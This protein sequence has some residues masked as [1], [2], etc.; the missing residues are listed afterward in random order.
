MPALRPRRLTCGGSREN[1][2]AMR[3]VAL[4]F[5][6]LW[7]GASLAAQTPVVSAN[8]D[9]MRIRSAT[10]TAAAGGAFNVGVVVEN[11]NANA[12]LPTTW[13]RWW[14]F[15]VRNLNAAG[16]TMTFT[17]DSAS[18]YT[19]VILPVWSLST[20]GV[21]FSAYERCPTS[22]TPTVLSAGRHRFTLTTPPGTVAI[23]VAKYFPYTVARKNAWVASLQGRPQLRSTTVI[24]SSVQGRPI[25]MLELTDASVPDA[26]K[27]RVWIHSGIHPSESTSYLVVEGLVDWLCS[28]DP[29]A[30]SFLDRCI[31]TIVPMA[32][33][34]GVFLGNYRANANS[35][36]LESQW[37]APY[38]SSQPE[39][40]ALRTQ[41][42][43]FMGTVASPAANPIEVV[44]NLHASHNLA[45]PFHF[46]HSA[47]ASWTAGATGVLPI[48]NQREQQWIN[49]FKQRSPFVNLGATQSSSAGF[50]TRPYVESMMHDRWTA[51][52]GWLNSP[53]FLEPVMAI[54]FEGTYGRG[55]DQS[56]WNDEADYRLC[57][58]QMGLA[59]CDYL[60]VV[61]GTVASPYGSS[62]QSLTLVGQ[63]SPP[64]G[65]S[66]TLL[67]SVV[68]APANSL[69][70]LGIGAQQVQTPLPP[71]FAPCVL[72]SS[73][74]Q[75][76][77][78]LSSAFGSA[79]WSF[80]VP[81]IPGLTAWFQ[82]G[83]LD[84]SG[85][86]DASN[87]LRVQNQF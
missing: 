11:D 66:P 5:L 61:P 46:L 15:E 72:L 83:S 26:G 71:P 41:I 63:L 68:G 78:S 1:L 48:V 74:D 14:H 32:N 20:D 8:G 35:V 28:N 53:N 34:D 7:A 44:L 85:A 80:V 67:A 70:L 54:T 21:T 81:P 73:L 79:Q 10:V 58:E 47:N 4:V 55:P 56:T 25:E 86:L 42:E 77:V 52:N 65:L 30:L 51:V 39:V 6:S 22:A 75:T 40:V 84:G 69:V 62:C 3:S 49:Q 45:Y 12:S 38:N 2:L 76:L 50:P 59:L 33:P 9:T 57:G 19:D 87:G 23:R 17:V 37:A 31:L 82:A 13:R 27:K 24:G 16:T 18:G 64:S 29:F 60:G 43:G 36:E